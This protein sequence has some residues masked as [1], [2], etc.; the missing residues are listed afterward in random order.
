[1]TEQE[2]QAIKERVEKPLVE[3]LYAPMTNLAQSHA[4]TK[5]LVAE[6]EQLKAENKELA[7]IALDDTY[8]EF[9]YRREIARL[10]EALKYYADIGNYTLTTIGHGYAQPEMMRDKGRSAREALK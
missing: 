3:K 10:R 6:V 8:N 1:M 4:D 5:K 7:A 9:N 2:L